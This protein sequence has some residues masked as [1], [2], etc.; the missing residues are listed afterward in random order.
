M[1]SLVLLVLQP[2]WHFPTVIEPKWNLPRETTEN[3]KW[4]KWKTLYFNF[5]YI[6]IWLKFL[7]HLLVHD[8]IT[9]I[10]IS[11]I[12]FVFSVSAYGIYI[13]RL[14]NIYSWDNFTI[15]DW[16]EELYI[17]TISTDFIAIS[18]KLAAL[19]GSC[20]YIRVFPHVFAAY[21]I[22]ITHII[23]HV[24]NSILSYSCERNR[25]C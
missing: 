13:L 5:S 19:T 16:F 14:T 15:I 20:L 4:I 8:G 2:K 23:E 10:K 1:L 3:E 22:N 21:V 25:L 11:W 6:C 24:I 9:C 7:R 17:N 12:I 18:C